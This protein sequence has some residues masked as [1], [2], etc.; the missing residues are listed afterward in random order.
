[1]LNEKKTSPTPVAV[2]GHRAPEHDLHYYKHKAAVL[3]KQVALLL[4][5][6]RHLPPCVQA[7]YLARIVRLEKMLSA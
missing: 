1:M 2:Q 6:L 3:D 7:R 4:G 5:A